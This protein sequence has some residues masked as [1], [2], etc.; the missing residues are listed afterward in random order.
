MF[1][2]IFLDAC[3]PRA[4][5]AA[6]CIAVAASYILFIAV[7]DGAGLVTLCAAMSLCALGSGCQMA[8]QSVCELFPERKFL[9][10]GLLSMAF[11]I[12]T[13][14]WLLLRSLTA[15][16]FAARSLFMCFSITACGYIAVAY[17]VP[18]N[19]LFSQSSLLSGVAFI[20]YTPAVL[21]L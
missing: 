15:V 4:T 9:V 2:G 7:V 16:G 8:V 18:L 21:S 11:Q 10:L 1:I 17:A 19:R 14:G 12:S 13:L 5:V 6:C 20:L 3:G